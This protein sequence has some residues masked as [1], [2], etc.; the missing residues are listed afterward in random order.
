M[1][2]GNKFPSESMPVLMKSLEN[3]SEDKTK[4]LFALRLK[5]PIIGLILSFFLGALGVDRFYKG[6][7]ALGFLKLFYL[8]FLYALV[9]V[10]GMSS[11]INSSGNSDSSIVIV[12]ILYLIFFIIHWIWIIADLFLVYK[13][14]KKDNLNKVTTLLIIKD[15]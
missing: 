3:T 11:I 15:L 8:V 9:I 4:M 6:D 2:N 12:E 7:I 13:G 1:V 5:K 14:I 10:V